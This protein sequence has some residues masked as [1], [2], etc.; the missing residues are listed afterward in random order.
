MH[1]SRTAQTSLEKYNRPRTALMRCTTFS[2]LILDEHQQIHDLERDS[3]RG[4]AKE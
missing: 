2:F 1:L 3:S 4:K